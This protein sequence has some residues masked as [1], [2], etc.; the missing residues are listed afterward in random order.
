MKIDFRPLFSKFNEIPRNAQNFKMQI[1]DFKE[2]RRSRA[3][4]II[5]AIIK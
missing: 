4:A 2:Q 3:V 5:I 1:D